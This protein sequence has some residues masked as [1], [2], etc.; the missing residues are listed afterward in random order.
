MEA[1]TNTQN[2]YKAA[3]AT[4]ITQESPNKE[5]MISIKK[6]IEFSFQDVKEVVFLV[7]NAR[8]AINRQGFKGKNIKNRE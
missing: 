6:V 2:S 3:A 8:E 4:S 5:I 1:S 7:Q